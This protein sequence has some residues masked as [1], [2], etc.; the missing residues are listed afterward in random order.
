MLIFF[1]R[2]I[3][4]TSEKTLQTIQNRLRHY[5]KNMSTEILHPPKCIRGMTDLNKD[6]FTKTIKVSALLLEN[7]AI[8]HTIMPQIKRKLLRMSNLKPIFDHE[9]KRMVLLHPISVTK[10]EDLETSVLEEKGVKPGDF[11]QEFELTLTY[12]NWRAD[13]LLR[14]ILP[15]DQEGMS[16]FSRIGHIIHLNLK[17][18]LLPFKKVI[19]EILRDKFP[20]IRT[21]VNKAQTIDNVY[22]NFS[23]ELLIG[24]AD[25]QVAVK[26]NGVEFEFDFSLVYWNPRLSAE[27]DRVVK[28]LNEGDVLYDIFAGVGPFAVP[29]AKKGVEVFANDLNPDSH[30][31][32]QHNAKKNKVDE[33][34]VTFNKD[35]REFLCDFVRK[36]FLQ[37]LKNP[38]FTG[39]MHFVMN[40]PALAVEFLDI[41]RGFLNTE[42]SFPFRK[43][44]VVHVY[45]FAK[46]AEKREK[47]ALDLVNEHLGMTLPKN[48]FIQTSFVRNV[49]PNKDMMR[50]DFFLTQQI[51]F[52]NADNDLEPPLKKSTKNL[53]FDMLN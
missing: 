4:E 30:K 48:A 31:W 51:L 21:V 20:G 35:G 2:V 13:E 16:S 24:D 53:F 38:E 28:L 19:A 40:L 3:V 50:V 22:R 18:H 26:E 47:I 15:E 11:I 17:E 12:A 44:P 49:A 32:L 5:L 14:F 46:G 43:L 42:V 37:R 23:M 10:Y 41:F 9:T 39:V 36:D 8:I 52:F 7:Q 29:A 33:K 34:I 45:C 27:H 6:L 25:Y 1:P